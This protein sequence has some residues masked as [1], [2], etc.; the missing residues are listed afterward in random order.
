MRM[1]FPIPIYPNIVHLCGYRL[2]T[3][4]FWQTNPVFHRGNTSIHAIEDRSEPHSPAK[5][6]VSKS[7]KLVL[8]TK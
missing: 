3:E 8:N 2:L 1:S 7:G 5:N 6:T 4:K